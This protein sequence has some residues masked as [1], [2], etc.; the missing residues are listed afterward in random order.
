[1]RPTTLR[2]EAKDR[3]NQMGKEDEE[4]VLTHLLEGRDNC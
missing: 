3:P 2:T 1:M 4:V